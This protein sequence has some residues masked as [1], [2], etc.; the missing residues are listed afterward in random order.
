MPILPPPFFSPPS[1]APS[2]V[3]STG[4][5]DPPPPLDSVVCLLDYVLFLPLCLSSSPC[6]TSIPLWHN[7]CIP[8]SL[9]CSFV[10]RSIGGCIYTS[11]HSPFPVLSVRISHLCH[12]RSASTGCTFSLCRATICSLAYLVDMFDIVSVHD[13][14]IHKF[15][16]LLRS[17]VAHPSMDRF[18]PCSSE[19]VSL[20]C[21]AVKNITH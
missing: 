16:S 10:N 18:L 12:C 13:V 7:C 9:C 5:S 17:K 15:T 20:N 21:E 11:P 4:R 2:T 14:S 8:H 3:L 6:R 19:M 1:S